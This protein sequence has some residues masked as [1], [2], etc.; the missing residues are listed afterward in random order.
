LK[1]CRV[2]KANLFF[3]EI[4]ILYK[5]KNFVHITPIAIIKNA[6]FKNIKDILYFQNKKYIEIFRKFL[7]A[8]DK[9]YFNYLNDKFIYP[10]WF[11]FGKK[12]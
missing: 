1:I 2:I 10:V 8:G 9:V 4:M 7:D 12:K 6:S 11:Q 3:Y 5:H